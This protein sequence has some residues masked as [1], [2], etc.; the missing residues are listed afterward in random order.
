MCPLPFGVLVVKSSNN[1]L[2]SAKEKHVTSALIAFLILIILGWD[3]IS[4]FV[5][6]EPEPFIIT[7]CKASQI[8]Q[9]VIED[10]KN[11]Y[12]EVPDYKATIYLQP[13]KDKLQ[14][15]TNAYIT[16]EVVD[17]GIIKLNNSYFYILVYD[18][19]GNL[20]ISFPCFCN[21]EPTNL[22]VR[23]HCSYSTISGNDCS[24]YSDDMD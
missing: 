3:S 13:K 11:Q 19:Q 8:E 6:N 9:I 24:F 4:A 5:F 2:V 17:E 21:N 16:M 14:L 23:A 20:R 15:N 22:G 10:I 12:I 7:G 18:P 1:I